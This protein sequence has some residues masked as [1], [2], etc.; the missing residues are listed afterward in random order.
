M[1]IFVLELAHLIDGKFVQCHSCPGSGGGSR[2]FTFREEISALV[3]AY[4]VK[5][6]ISSLNEEKVRG[7]EQKKPGTLLG[8]KM[9]DCCDPNGI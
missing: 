1:V 8:S 6:G 2:A 7:R 9:P 3:D 5:A 4:D